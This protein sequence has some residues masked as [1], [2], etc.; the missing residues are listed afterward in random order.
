[1]AAQPQ[2]PP[3]DAD[4]ALRHLL[5]ETLGLLTRGPLPRR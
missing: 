4:P 3:A 1:M 2:I 5:A